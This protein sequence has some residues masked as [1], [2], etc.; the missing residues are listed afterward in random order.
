MTANTRDSETLSVQDSAPWFDRVL[1]PNFN[2]RE[3][4]KRL[5]AAID[6]I[7]GNKGVM[8]KTGIPSRT[9]SEYLAGGEMKRPALVALAKACGVN[10]AWL[11][12]GEGPMVGELQAQPQSQP[13]PQKSAIDAHNPERMR[14]AIEQAF[15]AFQEREVAPDGNMLARIAMIYYA[16]LSREEASLDSE[17]T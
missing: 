14:R 12:A 15:E 17:K 6:R 2:G 10:I 3:P 7:G 5:R 13:E 8:A 1:G 9:L 4:A 16:A 11:A